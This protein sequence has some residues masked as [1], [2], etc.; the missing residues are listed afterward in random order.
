MSDIIVSEDSTIVVSLLSGETTIL[1]SQA[2]GPPGRDGTSGGSSILAIAGANLSGHMGIKLVSGSAFTI[3][4]SD[5]GTVNR[6]IG[7]SK[8][9][10]AINTSIEIVVAGELDG[11]SGLIP[12][13]A[14]YL[15]DNGTITNSYPTNGYIQQVGIAIS[16]TKALIKIQPPIILG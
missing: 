5:I 1:T 3:S 10:A 6:L 11:F 16:S 2:Q 12:D 4:N 9:S 14:L 15:Q 8:T 7:V 13:S